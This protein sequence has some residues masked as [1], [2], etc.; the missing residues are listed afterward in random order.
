MSGAEPVLIGLDWGTSSLRAYLIN[1]AGGM[2]DRRDAASGILKVEDGAFEAVFRKLCGDWLDHHPSIPI[3]ASGM[4]TSR[5]GWVETAYA[6]CPAGADN[7]ADAVKPH[8]LEDGRIIHFTPG[9]ALENDGRGVPDVMRGEET[10]IIGVF[11]VPGGGQRSATAV[12]PGTHSKWVTVKAGRI[13]RFTTFMTGEVYG[14]LI[15]HTILG[16]VVSNAREDEEAFERGLTLGL[17]TDS[18]RGGLLGRLFSARTLVLFD[19]L[20]GNAVP[21]YVSGLV[22]GSEINEAR[23][24]FAVD[25]AVDDDDIV[26]IG[27]D[28]LANRYR[29]ALERAGL[30]SKLS[31]PDCAAKGLFSIAQAKGLM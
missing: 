5:Q 28:R 17:E 18:V 1:G 10:Q 21:S 12:M 27:G 31:E 2:I 29:R 11:D 9:V 3:V 16:R 13:E 6:F 24:A 26:I 19:K 4:I 14:A 15:D 25:E 23:S 8:Q 20:D 7:I 30:K 22:L